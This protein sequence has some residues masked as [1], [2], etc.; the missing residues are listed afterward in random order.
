[1]SI[2][3]LGKYSSNNVGKMQVLELRENSIDYNSFTPTASNI[4]NLNGITNL[5]G[6]YQKVGNIVMV[7]ITG[8]IDELIAGDI[9]FS[10]KLTAFPDLV[11]SGSNDAIIIANKNLLTVGAI[12]CNVTTIDLTNEIRVSYASSGR[13]SNQ[14]N[15]FITFHF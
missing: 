2:S 10:I 5:E 6:K 8:F 15:I 9:S 7:G 14:L 11:F 12:S 3:N 13:D 4:I 1:M